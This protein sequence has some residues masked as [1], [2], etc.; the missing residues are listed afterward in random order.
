MQDLAELVPQETG[1]MIQYA[2]GIRDLLILTQYRDMY[3]CVGH[4]T[5]DLHGRDTDHPEPRVPEFIVY[6]LVTEYRHAWIDTEAA[7]IGAT[8]QGACHLNALEHLDLVTLVN[9]VVLDAD[10]ALG[11]RLDL[12]DVILEAPQGFKLAF[13]D[14][15]VVAQYTN[16]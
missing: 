13:I 3:F 2:E 8:L 5:R 10:T 12:V 4:V 9:A 1:C 6:H 14:H 11:T 7:E 16:R 15:D